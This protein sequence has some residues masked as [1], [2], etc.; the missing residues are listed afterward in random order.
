M[1][2]DTPGSPVTDA[3]VF[4]RDGLVWELNYRGELDFLHQ[5]RRQEAD[6][7]LTVHD[8]WAYFIHGWTSVISEVY[9]IEIG[10]DLL[11][12]LSQIAVDVRDNAR[13]RS[14]Q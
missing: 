3:G 6:R 4:P 2:K 1:G 10:P 12:R 9:D 5:A 8:G 13:P 14:D 7:G 11:R